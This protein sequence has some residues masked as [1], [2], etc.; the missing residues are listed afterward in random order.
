MQALIA[1]NNIMEI[2]I[3]FVLVFVQ[4][5][6]IFYGNHIGQQVTNNNAEIFD[7]VYKL[8]WYVVSQNIQKLMLFL[9]QK[10][11][12]TFYLSIGSIYNASYEGFTTLATSAI[13]YFTV[14]YAVQ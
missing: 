14:I 2:Y 9:L 7:T 13:S 12:K 4:I 3:S 10:G 8:Q 11:N 5:C 1:Y 6:I